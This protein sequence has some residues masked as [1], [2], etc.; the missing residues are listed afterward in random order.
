MTIPNYLT[1]IRIALIPVFILAFYLPFNWAPWLSAAIF[2][3]AALTDW[4]DGYLARILSQTSK[5]G[6]FLDPV[7]DKLFVGIALVLIVGQEHG[8]YLALPAA[9]IVGR[10]ILISG[11]REWMAELGKRTQV[12]VSLIAKIKTFSQMAAILLLLVYKPG[13]TAFLGILGGV[14][15]Y[16]AAMLTL[17]SMVLYIQAAWVDI[18]QFPEVP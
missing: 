15:L 2:G 16:V 9:V 11:L 17:W 10:E 7:A 18:T 1:F 13:H 14:C 12:K 6:A 8:T 5:F 3:F 4:L